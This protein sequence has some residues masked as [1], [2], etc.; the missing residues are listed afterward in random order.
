MW[1]KNLV[2]YK[3]K[4]P[5]EYSL[6]ELEP[7]MEKAAFRPCGSQEPVSFGW[8]P[9]MGRLSSQLVHIS[10]GYA[11]ICLRKEERLLPA[12]VVKEELD[13]R[14]EDI[15][16]KEHRKLRRQE[17]NDLRENIT[18]ELMPRAFTRAR[19]TYALYAPQEGYLLVDASSFNRAEELTALLRKNL[20]SLPIAPITSKS[21]PSAVMTRWVANPNTVPAKVGV[22]MECE[23]QDGGDEGGVVR[24]RRQALDADEIQSHLNAGKQVTKLAIDWDERLELVIDQDLTLKR[25]KYSDELQEKANDDADGDPAVQFDAEFT[26]MAMELMQLMPQLLSWFDGDQKN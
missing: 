8:V 20:G 21:A 9:P 24:C 19:P 6:E 11:L 1:F 18:Q 14:V 16:Q 3:I 7:A 17:K 15:E 25:V 22:G 5:L 13:L 10:Q 2:I 23:M 12:S 4:E 26:L